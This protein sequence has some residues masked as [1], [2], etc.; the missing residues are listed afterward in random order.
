MEQH[1][2]DN[3]NLLK[4]RHS[5][6]HVLMEAMEELFPGIIK[7]MGPATKDGFY[8]DFELPEDCKISEADFPMIEQRMQEIIDKNLT[9]QMKTL[10]IDEAR[11]LFVNNPYKQE[12]INEIAKKNSEPTIFWTGDHE[13]A[14]YDLC[15]GPHVETTSQIKAFKL[16]SI[17]GAYW[18]GNSNN[19]MLVRLYGTAFE[20][21]KELRQFLFNR[22]EAKKRDHRKL[23][24]ELGLFTFA[25]ESVGQGLPLWLPKGTVLRD[26]LEKWV[27]EVE[28]L[29]GYQRVITPV[30][31]KE[32]L[33]ECS[34]HLAYF[35]EDMYAPIQI[36]DERYYLRPMN[37]PHHHQIYKSDKRSYREL[38]YRIAEYGTA[39]RYEASGALSGLM[40]TRSFCQNDAHIYC[41]EA[42]AE[43]EFADVLKMYLY[44]YKTLGITDYYMRL[45]KPDLSEG[46]KYINNPEQWEKAMHIV[47]RAMQA[48]N[49]PYIEVDGEAA[50]YGPKIDVQIKS[51]IG[52]EYTISTNQL[53]FLAAERF[54]L[55]YVGD[56]GN[57]HQVYVIHRAPLG[58]HERMIAYLIEHFAGAFP[59]WLSPVQMM[60][61]PVSD[62][63]IDYCKDIQRQL[64]KSGLRVEI[65]LI[66]DTLSYKIRTSVMQ[67]IPYIAV[68][69]DKEA[70]SKTLS[71]RDRKNVQKHDLSLEAFIKMVT[72]V[73]E[74]KSLELWD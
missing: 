35:K 14:F 23:G 34:G 67:K 29:H 69:G 2:S 4:I 39:F 54:D 60:I 57:L 8:F 33:Y 5:C 7:A 61:I 48:V 24:K 56:D 16:L 62:K 28:A 58:S 9:F 47:R 11:E 40:R 10:S 63:H 26:E 49:F 46:S 74:S 50:F 68:I 64:L 41:S 18:R 66:N 21:A 72:H 20:S 71:I 45:S 15:A 32:A 38:P 36:E 70:E 73:I 65:N 17:A 42:Q 55:N 44:Y 6:E 43:A 1:I 19:K 13:Q 25:P 3:I 37:C 27:K 59:V 52:T 22:E 31:G 12:W 30:I 51:A 53:D